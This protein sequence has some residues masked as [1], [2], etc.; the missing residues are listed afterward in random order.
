MIWY[1]MVWE[2]TWHQVPNNRLVEPSQVPCLTTKS[3]WVG[4]P[5]KVVP[6]WEIIDM[7]AYQV[8]STLVPGIKYQVSSTKYQ[9]SSIRIFAKGIEI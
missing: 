9:I 6:T 2:T 5:D 7:G 1:G 8:P 3:K 4:E